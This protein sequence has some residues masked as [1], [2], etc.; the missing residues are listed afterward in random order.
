MKIIQNMKLSAKFRLLSVSFFLFLILFGLVGISQ[1]SSVN[2]KVI[3]LND[4]RLLPIVTLENLKSRMETTRSLAS[5]YMNASDDE[6]RTALKEELSSSLAAVQEELSAYEQTESIQQV[7]GAYSSYTSAIEAFLETFSTGMTGAGAGVGGDMPVVPE[8]AGEVPAQGEGAVQGG[9]PAEMENL[10]LA[11]SELITAMDAWIDGHIQAAHQ[12]YEDS[13]GVYRGTLITMLILIVIS[14][15]FITFITILISK[16]VIIPVTKVSGKLKEISESNGDLTVRLGYDSKDEL[17]E[18]S[19]SFDSFITRLQDMVAGVIQSAETIT[20]S[21]EHLSQATGNTTATL[22]EIARTIGEISTGTTENAAVAQQASASLAEMA[23]FS[24]STAQAS[25][26]TAKSSRTVKQSAEDG[27]IKIQRIR[28]SIEDMNHSSQSVTATLQQLSISSGRIGE[29]TALIT[30]IAAQTNLLSLNAAIEAARAGEAGKGFAVVADEIRKLADESAIAA[31]EISQ[32]VEDNRTIS[33]EAVH[34]SDA[35]A[36]KVQQGVAT[37]KEAESSML[38]I[39]THIQDISSQIEHIDYDNNQQASSTREMEQAIQNIAYS[40]GD[41]A[42]GTEQIN[43]SVQQQL[44]MMTEIDHT[45]EGL[46]EM[47]RQLRTMTAG[48]T[49]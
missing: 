14:A 2:K 38:D 5:D 40:T 34:S 27:T 18:L 43:A 8:S 10:D 39:M 21:S 3:E 24:N 19:Q 46:A 44:G 31:K 48:F 4:S 16:S 36:K 7:V 30:G 45:A 41:I 13:Q 29:I 6:E 49:V 42:G 47:A 35:V 37:A 23:R 17:G 33:V 22:Q 11:K 1:I 32:L 28:D 12:T 15:V 9:P 26:A 25:Q 20:A